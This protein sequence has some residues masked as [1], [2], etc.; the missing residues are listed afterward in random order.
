MKLSDEKNCNFSSIPG[1]TKK[2]SMNWCRGNNG[3]K[4]L[5]KYIW[6]WQQKKVCMPL[7]KTCQSFLIVYL[8]MYTIRNTIIGLENIKIVGHFVGLWFLQFSNL[9]E[10]RLEFWLYKTL[11]SKIPGLVLQVYILQNFLLHWYNGL[12]C[13]M[14]NFT[15]LKILRHWKLTLLSATKINWNSL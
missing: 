5:G 14:A 10:K 11:L 7:R 13:S 8:C 15:P 12:T 1:V 2:N 9:W 3:K 6:Q 4:Y